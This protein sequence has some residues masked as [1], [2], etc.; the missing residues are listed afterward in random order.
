MNNNYTSFDAQSE[1]LNTVQQEPAKKARTKKS[2]IISLL[3]LAFGIIQIISGI[4]KL[5]TALSHKNQNTAQVQQEQSYYD[6]LD[7]DTLRILLRNNR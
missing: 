4:H 3:V 1:E 5:S 2:I 7:S 6:S